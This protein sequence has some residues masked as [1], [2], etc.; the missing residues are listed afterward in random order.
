MQFANFPLP[1]CLL[2]PLD[3]SAAVR[4]PVKMSL[5]SHT[6]NN[7]GGNPAP[8]VASDISYYYE[9]NDRDHPFYNH[10]D[11]AASEEDRIDSNLVC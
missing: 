4:P 5:S 6:N 1:L 7:F 2:A 10:Y 9:N 11:S 3:H 8:N